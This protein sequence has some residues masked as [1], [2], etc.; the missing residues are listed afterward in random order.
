MISCQ[1]CWD[2]KYHDCRICPNRPDLYIN[3]DIP[4]STNK[5]ELAGVLILLTVVLIIIAM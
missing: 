4:K 2:K 5:K 3:R 1:N